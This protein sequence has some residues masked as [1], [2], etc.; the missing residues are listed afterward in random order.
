MQ[1]SAWLCEVEI[2]VVGGKGKLG[3]TFLG[4]VA[5]LPRMVAS[6]LAFGDEVQFGSISCYLDLEL[7]R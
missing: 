5:K 3:Q 2:V 4:R 7:S 1:Y 6:T